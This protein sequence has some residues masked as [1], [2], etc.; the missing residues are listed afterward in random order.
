MSC[1]LVPGQPKEGFSAVNAVCYSWMKKGHFND[2]G[3][4]FNC[5]ASFDFT[6]QFKLI[7]Q[8]YEV[9]SDPKKRDLYDHGGEQAV[10]EGGVSGGDFSSPMDIFNMFFGGGG[11]TQRERRGK[12]FPQGLMHTKLRVWRFVL[13]VHNWESSFQHLGMF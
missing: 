6:W 4:V 1:V 12:L 13:N 5:Y 10:K 7:S 8:A 2:L 9:L 3:N 11:R